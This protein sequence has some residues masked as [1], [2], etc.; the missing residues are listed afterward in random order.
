MLVMKQVYTPDWSR[1]MSGMIKSRVSVMSSPSG[2]LHWTPTI[3]VEVPASQD[4][5]TVSPSLTVISSTPGGTSTVGQGGVRLA[6]EWCTGNVKKLSFCK[7][8]DVVA[9]K[10]HVQNYCT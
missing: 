5:E 10:G 3:L 9:V 8:Y 4:S 1:C 2:P 6:L 7:C